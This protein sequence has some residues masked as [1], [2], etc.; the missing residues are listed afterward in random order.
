MTHP[1]ENEMGYTSC[2]NRGLATAWASKNLEGVRRVMLD[3][4]EKNKPSDA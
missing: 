3:G 1:M 4:Y 2:Q